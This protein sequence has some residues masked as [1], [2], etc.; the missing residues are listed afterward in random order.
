MD[1]QVSL[2][3]YTEKRIRD[4]SKVMA[5]WRGEKL[6][7]NSTLERW[8]AGLLSTHHFYLTGQRMHTGG[9]LFKIIIVCSSI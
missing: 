1:A 7:N 2:N 9:I 8:L 6:F 5:S 4:E 3:C